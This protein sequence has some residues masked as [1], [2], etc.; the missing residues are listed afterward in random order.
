MILTFTLNFNILI[1]T[2]F[3]QLFIVNE[4]FYFIINE[5]FQ[6]F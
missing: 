1:T 2:L 4:S 5:L 3:Y 6:N